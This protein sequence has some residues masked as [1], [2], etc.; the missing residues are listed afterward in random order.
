MKELEP[1]AIPP[2]AYQLL[3]LAGSTHPA[4]LVRY[5]DEYFFGVYFEDKEKENEE[6]PC[7]LRQI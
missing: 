7:K 6:T 1:T 3:L 2:M 4:R 5:F